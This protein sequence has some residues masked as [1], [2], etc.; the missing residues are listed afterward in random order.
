MHHRNN[1]RKFFRFV[2]WVKQFMKINKK[3]MCLIKGSYVR[4]VGTISSLLL[5]ILIK[6]TFCG[7][8]S[9]MNFNIYD[10]VL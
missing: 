10:I 5:Y 9:S 8:I 3:C 4:C 7:G 2:I 6:Y 1:I